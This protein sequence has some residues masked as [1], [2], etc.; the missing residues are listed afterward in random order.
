VI[1]KEIFK[2]YKKFQKNHPILKD[3][4]FAI[5][6][7]FCGKN[8]AVTIHDGKKIYI[9]PK[10]ISKMDNTSLDVLL[11]HELGHVYAEPKNNYTLRQSHNQ[12]WYKACRK[13]GWSLELE[14]ILNQ[15]LRGGTKSFARFLKLWEPNYWMPFSYKQ[16]YGL[17][18]THMKTEKEIKEMLKTAYDCW[19]AADKKAERNIE[20][21]QSELFAFMAGLEFA[22]GMKPENH[23]LESFKRGAKMYKKRN[24]I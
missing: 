10:Y 21:L 4:K 12:L 13:I 3:W 14:F 18:K 15:N 24:L 8:I 16:K 6:E 7:N 2:I 22:L 5:D 9:S 23:W 11:L 1:E 19:I 17:L 20:D